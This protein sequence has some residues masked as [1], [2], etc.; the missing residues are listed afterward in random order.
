MSAELLRLELER[1]ARGYR[2]YRLWKRLALTWAAIALGALLLLFLGY[3]TKGVLLPP[4]G[5][6]GVAALGGLIAAALSL[7]RLDVRT[8]AAMIEREHPELQTL[9][10]AAVDQ[11]AQ[12][13]RTSY[14]QER[15]FIKA[16]EANRR[17]PWDQRMLERLF[18]VQSASA[19][20]LLIL[21]GIILAT[22][23]IPHVPGARPSF[24]ANSTQIEI[25]PGDTSVERGQPLV[26]LAK[27]SAPVPAEANLVVTAR[28]EQRTMPLA[29]SLADPVF[30]TSITEVTNE[31]TYAVTYKGKKTRDYKVSVFEYPTLLRADAELDFPG[32]TQLPRKKIDDTRHISAVEGTRLAL[33]MQL[34]K[35]VA[36][37]RL[38]GRDRSSIP[39]ALDEKLPRVS[40]PSLVLQTSNTFSLELIDPEGRT[41]NAPAHFVV[42]VLKNQAPELKLAHPRGDSRVSPLEE[43][44]IEAQAWDDFGIVQYGIAY[45]FG[46]A[47]EKKLVLGGP[48][49]GGQ[50]QTITNQV[51]M[52]SLGA[53][54][55]QLLSY[56]FWAE[57][58]GPDGT[59]RQTVSDMFFA[60]VRPFEEIFREGS[61]SG[62]GDM[63]AMGQSGNQLANLVELQKQ[64]VTATWK[65][66]APQTKPRPKYADDVGVIKESQEHI[67]ET[68]QGRLDRT[69][70]PTSKAALETAVK[71]MEGAA[72]Q[73]GKA[74]QGGAKLL[75]PAL[76]SEQNA[77]Q[78][79]LK[80]QAREF[81]VSQSRGGGGGGQGR[82]GQMRQ[83]DQLE[84][85]KAEDRYE[86]QRKASAAQTPEQ[87]EQLEV[88]NRLK[89]LAQRQQDLNSRI[90]ELQSALEDAKTEE[91]KA[92]LR[93][94]LARLRDQQQEFVRDLDEL[95]QKMDQ[96]R[97][98]SQLAEN[99]QQLDQTRNEA[100]QASDAMEKGNLS[101]ALTSGT[102]A[103]RNLEEMRDKLRKQSANQFADAM[104]EM[105]SEARELAQ[106]Q[107]DLGR[108][109][110]P[111]QEGSRKTLRSPGGQEDVLSQ[112]AQQKQRLTNIF[113]QMTRVIE[114]S[115]VPEPLLS[116]ELYDT[117]R[118][119]HQSGIEN[120]LSLT[121]EFLKRG[122]GQEA[123][124]FEDRAD[125]GVTQLKQGIERAAES[126]LGD[127]V[128]ALKMASKEL[129]E[130]QKEIEKEAPAG[131]GQQGTNAPSAGDLAGTR[132]PGEE[133]RRAG[134]DGPPGQTNRAP[135]LLSGAG[136]EGTNSAGMSEMMRRRYG[137]A[138]PRTPNSGQANAGERPDGTPGDLA[139]N[140]ERSE[141]DGQN[142]NQPGQGR[143]Q[144]S[145]SNQPGN[146]PG[147]N[148]RSQGRSN[149]EGNQ[150]GSGQGQGGG[151][152]S[153]EGQRASG[154]Q[155]R[156]GEGGREGNRGGR[157]GLRQTGGANRGGGG[158]GPEWQ[159]GWNGGPLTGGNYRDWADRLGNVEE[160]LDYP[161]M[162]TD[163]SR[164][165]EQARVMRNDF[166]EAGKKPEWAQLQLQIV[167]PLAE[168][169][170][171][172][173][174][175]LLRRSSPEA[176]APIDR[177]PVPN[178][179]S[180]LVRRY[181][182]NLGKSP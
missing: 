26:I 110:E 31:F 151:S 130:L 109:L 96:P 17:A 153:S 21:T 85:T 127:E 78:A 55:D 56:Y 91:Q 69:T 51:S 160:L 84:M 1:I 27:F 108:Q 22:G 134:A 47:E 41:N 107:E 48:I 4:A 177:D 171:R 148:E 74:A 105:R 45:S 54:P 95:R 46:N 66:A 121:S 169:R 119:A 73:L 82:Q 94:Q 38:I 72:S 18:Y 142:R 98:N 99:R 168:I 76:R 68:A 14:L 62:E 132:K 60:E 126:V 167:A 7:R 129:E 146:Q 25:T 113:N 86:K 166:K 138:D 163:L 90:K 147:N 136:G 88:L 92:E 29:K 2:R 140:R 71:E 114:Q 5:L 135:S 137:L 44:Q 42:N 116:K 24:F 64:V 28:G 87:K 123:V 181:Y 61:G 120:N 131:S 102:R 89:E 139:M 115:E 40:L 33:T 93:R 65:L 11:L 100:R 182:E 52:E 180:E 178:K 32:Y 79:L 16:L 111:S 118:K 104:K 173:E 133:G 179:F 159:S 157:A 8:A 19:A 122:L 59:P 112:L 15:V 23:L 43:L 170:H 103:E 36:S 3:R 34:N 80:L 49:P 149:E 143:N 172:V 13:D 145:Q 9:L 141:R 83:L 70:D 117:Y 35:K 97:S 39:L 165:R 75:P 158:G 30:A 12:P 63:S 58:A 175:E 106:K 174:E 124:K 53:Q 162:R 20:A 57:D 154:Q 164:I 150:P 152:E 10:L 50:K 77:Y 155:G 176:L 128:E 6:I 125:T 161:D 144:R 101:Q 37:A 67:L 156:A 81:Q